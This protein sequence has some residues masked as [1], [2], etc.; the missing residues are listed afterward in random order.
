MVAGSPLVVEARVKGLPAPRDP[1]QAAYYRRLAFMTRR[2]SKRQL[3][4]LEA[5]Q[6]ET[7]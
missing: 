5:K 1:A 7:S 2:P 4:I 3:A 6:K